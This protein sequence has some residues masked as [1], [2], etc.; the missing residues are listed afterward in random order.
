MKIKGFTLAEVLITLGVIGIVAAMTMPMM[1][2]GYRKKQTAAQL[3]SIYSILSQA[4]YLS[5]VENGETKYWNESLTSK[6]YYESYLKKYLV[7]VNSEVNNSNIS[8]LITYKF[9]NGEDIGS[10]YKEE[11]NSSYLGVLANGAFVF[12]SVVKNYSTTVMVDIN[13]LK[14]PNRVGIDLFHFIIKDNSVFPWGIEGTVNNISNDTFG[15]MNDRAKLIDP[16]YRFACNNRR[17]GRWCTALIMMDGWEIKD[18][19]PWYSN[20]K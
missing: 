9:L 10:T 14:N 17:H 6:A 13:G 1:L 15:L 11:I 16:Q 8:K 18:D 19:Y 4:V 2:E 7:F 3:K 20:Q 5:V 12:I